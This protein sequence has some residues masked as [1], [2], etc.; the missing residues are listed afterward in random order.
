M[1]HPFEL[2]AVCISGIGL[3]ESSVIFSSDGPYASWSTAKSF[4][5]DSGQRLAVLDTEEKRTALVV[6]GM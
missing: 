2:L 4:C 6:Q 5:E 3:V 1:K